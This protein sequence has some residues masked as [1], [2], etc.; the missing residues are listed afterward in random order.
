LRL[1]GA[2][3]REFSGGARIGPPAE[4]FDFLG[5]VAALA[6]GALN[7]GVEPVQVAPV[8][9]MTAIKCLFVGYVFAQGS[10]AV[11]RR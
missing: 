8:T 3:E 1:L 10:P 7:D 2:S 4:R 11:R 5:V 6:R 9:G